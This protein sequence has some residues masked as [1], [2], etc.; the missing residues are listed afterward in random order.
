LEKQSLHYLLQILTLQVND[1]V[2][3]TRVDGSAT[4]A[5][6]PI[7]AVLNEYALRNLEVKNQIKKYVFLPD[8]EEQFQ[9]KIQEL[10]TSKSNMGP[11][12]AP[13]DT[14]RGKLVILLSWAESHIKRFAAELL[15]TLCNSD[16]T[17]YVHRVGM[18]NALPLLNAKGLASIP[19]FKS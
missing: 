19:F 14:L 15:W 4:A 12:D 3:N 7:L 6:V 2:D 10:Q 11:L 16:A 1:V 5:L 9:K 18:G 8:A 17:Q 13:N